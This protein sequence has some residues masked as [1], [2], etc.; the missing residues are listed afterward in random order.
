M[1]PDSV[2]FTV[3]DSMWS[4]AFEFFKNGRSEFDPKEYYEELPLSGQV[5]HIKEFP[6]VYEESLKYQKQGFE[7]QIWDRAIV[8]EIIRKNKGMK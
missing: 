7:L 1:T 6:A 8:D 2:S 4:F 5:F 3:N